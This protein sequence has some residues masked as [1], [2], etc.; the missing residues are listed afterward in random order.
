MLASKAHC[1]PSWGISE[2]RPGEPLVSVSAVTRTDVWAVGYSAADTY[3]A[4]LAFH[5]SK[6][7]WHPVPLPRASHIASQLNAVSMISGTQGWAV[8]YAQTAGGPTETGDFHTLAEQWTGSSWRIV[9]T[10]NIGPGADELDDVLALSVDDVWA[11]GYETP[12]G[13][14]ARKTLIEHWDG[15]GWALTPTPSVGTHNQALLSIAGHS[16]TPDD[17]WAVGYTT[18]AWSQDQA[19]VEHWNGLAWSVVPTTSATPA[20][21][22]TAV[23]M[24][25]PTDA[26]A[27]GYTD[28]D[29]VFVEHWNGV[30][31]TLVTPPG[32]TSPAAIARGVADLSPSD[33]WVVGTVYDAATSAYVGFTLH[34]NGSRWARIGA[35]SPRS[36]PYDED[37]FELRS[38]A[39]TPTGSLWSAG[40][41]VEDICPTATVGTSS[42]VATTY[43]PNSGAA[44]KDIL[45]GAQGSRSR[46]TRRN[47]A[48]SQ[49]PAVR[50]GARPSPDPVHGGEESPTASV[51]TEPIVSL[52]EATVAG[53]AQTTLGLSAS[54]GDFGQDGRESFFLSRFNQGGTLY[55]NNGNG[56]FTATDTNTF[57]PDD[58]HECVSA[59]IFGNGR[60]D[61]FCT[62]GAAH[63]EAVKANEMYIEGPDHTFVNEAATLGLL[64]P[65]GRGRAT[66]FLQVT[67]GSLPDL[68]VGNDTFRGDGLP[69]PDR[70]YMNTGHGFVDAPQYG[71]DLPIGAKCAVAGDYFNNGLDDLLVCPTNNSPIRLFQNEGGT[72]FVDVTKAAGLPS[73]NAVGA[74]FVDLNGDGWPD[75]V[76]VGRNK[77]IVLLQN[78]KTH[79]FRQSYV[80]PLTDGTAVA[81]IDAAGTGVPDL[82]VVQGSLNGKNVPDLMLMN[83]GLGTS[84]SSTAIPEVTRGGGVAAYPIDAQGNGSPDLLVL[85]APNLQAT[86]PLQLLGFFSGPLV[87]RAAAGA[88][89]VGVANDKLPT[90]LRVMVT[91]AGGDPVPGAEVTFSVPTSGPGCVFSN[92]RSSVTATTGPGGTAE[93]ACTARATTGSYS[94]TATVADATSSVLFSESTTSQKALPTVTLSATPTTTVVYGQPVTVHASVSNL[95]DVDQGLASLTFETAAGVELSCTGVNQSNPAS[96]SDTGGDLSATCTFAPGANGAEATEAVVAA[97]SGDS[98]VD[99]ATS[100]VETFTIERATAVLSVTATPPATPVGTPI[101]LKAVVADVQYPTAPIA[102]NVQFEEGSTVLC[103]VG[104]HYTATTKDAVATCD[105]IR[106]PTTLTTLTFSAEYCPIDEG[107]CTDWNASSMAS[108]SDTTVLDPTS[109]TLTPTTSEAN[110]IIL[111]DGQPTRVTATVGVGGPQPVDGSVTFWENGSPITNEGAEVCSTEAVGATGSASCTF[112]PTPDREDTLVATYMPNR[113]SLTGESTSP[114][115]YSLVGTQATT[116]SVALDSPVAYGVPVI[117]TATVTSQGLPVS[118]GTATFSVDGNVVPTCQAQPVSNTGT[119]ACS[120]LP[121]TLPVGTR[122]IGAAFVPA[123]G[124]LRS[125]AGSAALVI[126]SAPTSTV[127]TGSQTSTSSELL[128]IT[129]TDSAAGAIVAPRG[130]VTVTSG[131][132][133]SCTAVALAPQ[134]GPAAVAT[135]TVPVSSSTSTAYVAAYSPPGGTTSFLGSTAPALTV[136]PGSPSSG[137]LTSPEP[138]GGQYRHPPLSVRPVPGSSCPPSGLLRR[139]VVLWSRLSSLHRPICLASPRPPQDGQRR[140]PPP[141]GRRTEAG[142][143][144]DPGQ[145]AGRR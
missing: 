76:L 27:V 115:W 35:Q 12:P 145:Q 18:N 15:A 109:I 62:I 132:T 90:Q 32:M 122:T 64:D 65:T 37:L 68:F 25:G 55:L 30:E 54:V 83:N 77:L 14:S 69:D 20:G 41:L 72:R 73:F 29:D 128:T 116:T 140:E 71:L 131:T 133:V 89:Q 21:V 107:A 112:V 33:V 34:W 42:T 45:T 139:V 53:I 61:I 113:S 51:A 75:L 1:G 92:G 43:P 87:E 39:V 123:G 38:I 97:Y 124:T 80:L 10:P 114:S 93:V 86:E 144:V 141:A 6:G 88:T 110:P 31:W 94:V 81:P 26:W 96:V 24:S 59:D 5:E 11:T 95:P 130:T 4:P 66:T 127:A 120:L 17:L 47:A 142:Q 121:S 79:T 137:T 98:Q 99:A 108:A 2:Y 82:Y 118:A 104:V 117:A 9:T 40:T 7:V 36:T 78:P 50:T 91:S 19:L 52:E 103:T 85:N 13:A 129:V 56:T 3:V 23:S 100:N 22:L 125:S 49:V 111:A 16:S 126:A 119:A 70:L 44:D 58:R 48:T 74:A 60:L 8:G 138:G 102:G 28:S 136:G 135:C 67:P 105:A 134:G 143:A 63:S 57:V 101:A 106:A 46:Q 84:F